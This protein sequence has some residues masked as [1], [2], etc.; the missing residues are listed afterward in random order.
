MRGFQPKNFADGGLVQGVKR[1]FGMDEEHNARIAAYRAQQAQ[2]RAQQ[3]AAQQQAQQAAQ[4]AA[5]AVSDYAGMSA[6]KRREKAAGLDYADGG[7]VRGPGTGTSDD[8]PDKVREGTYIMPADSTDA[9]GADKLAAMGSR[10]FNPGG[11]KVPV[12]LSNGEF[13]IPPEQVHAVGVQALDQMKNATHRPVRGFAPKASP[14]EPRQFFRDGGVVWEDTDTLKAGTMAAGGAAYAGGKALAPI[15]TGLGYA[16]P[17]RMAADI[18]KTAATRA[19]KASVP[20]IPKTAVGGFAPALALGTTAVDTATTPTEDYRKRFGMETDDPSLMG[21]IGVRALGAASDLGNNITLGLAGKLFRDKQEAV[22]APAAPAQ[23]PTATSLAAGTQSAPVSGSLNQPKPQPESPSEP[24]TT[25]AREVVPGVFNHGRG[26]YSDQA[27]GM[28][29]PEGFTGQPSAENMARMDAI[30]NRSQQE[31]MARV[32]ARGF[33]G[34]GG[35]PG[36]GPVEPGSFTGGFSGVI[37][38]DP[39]KAQ[40]DRERSQLMSALTSPVA[41]ARGLTAAQ[42]NGTLQLMNQESQAAQAQDRNATALQQT[43]MQGD[44]QRETTGMR[45][46]GDTGRANARNSID[47]RRVAVE[48][49]VRGFDVR[50][51]QRQE[52]LYERYDAAKTPEERTAVAQQ[53]RDLQGKTSE[54]NARMEVVRG[55]VDPT[56]GKRDGDYAVIFDP[57]TQTARAV[58]VGSDAKA[59][60]AIKDNPAAIAIVNNTALSLEQRRAEL[61]KLGYN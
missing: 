52:K 12:N 53:I 42:R 34:A 8:V 33:P 28:G 10:G 5:P 18:A 41:G 45:E 6:M 44:V 14:E 27:S 60:P 30:A 2:E 49:Q 15:A 48:E 13:K 56:T 37:G 57:K 9:V 55:S 22:T 1:I 32:T 29:T 25:T 7:M 24:A 31:S 19:A 39:R 61:K 23:N 59:L 35:G 50:H 38:T 16:G 58:Q 43:R 20:G 40:Q 26:Q 3:Q 51:G 47:S 4:P 11:D 21:D 36:S 17:G 46:A 54:S